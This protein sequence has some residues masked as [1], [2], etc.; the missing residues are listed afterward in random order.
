M[1]PK[2]KKTIQETIPKVIEELAAMVDKKN[3]KL[4]RMKNYLDLLKMISNNH[5]EGG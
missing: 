1:K 5:K 2:Y 3:K 4:N